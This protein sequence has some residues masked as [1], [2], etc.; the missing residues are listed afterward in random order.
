M[1]CD[2]ITKII[3]PTIILS[4]CNYTVTNT[5]YFFFSAY[6]HVYV[7]L[8]ETTGHY[9]V[10]LN[11]YIKTVQHR[12]MYTRQ[13]ARSRDQQTLPKTIPR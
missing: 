7:K 13:H 4:V 11:K 8:F 12:Y 10:S 9:I 3:S 6:K 1:P 2:N 5:R